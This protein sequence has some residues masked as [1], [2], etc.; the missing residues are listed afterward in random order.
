MRHDAFL[1]YSHTDAHLARE[2]E[3]G[4]ESL[5]KPL[6]K[7][8]ALD[9]FRDETALASSPALWPSI[10]EHLEAS[11][12][13]VLLAS[14]QSAASPWCAKELGWWL[15][16][17]SV[18][19]LL[20]VMTDGDIIWDKGAGEFDFARSTALSRVIEG[21]FRDEPLYT[22]LRWARSER[23]LGLRHP[24]FRDA[25]LNIAAPLRGIPKD[26]LD[27]VDVRQ[28]RRNR[29][30]VRTL[31][32]SIAAALVVAIWQ[33]RTATRER[34]EAQAQARKALS[35]KLVADSRLAGRPLDQ[36]LLLAAEAYQIAATVDAH[37]NLILL[38]HE[39][40]RYEQSLHAHESPVTAAAFVGRQLVTGDEQGRLVLWAR[41]FDSPRRSL[42]EVA[43]ITTVAGQ[44]I[45]VLR[46]NEQTGRLAAVHRNGRLTMVQVGDRTLQGEVAGS[47]PDWTG[48]RVVLNADA[49]RA[50]VRRDDRT[51]TAWTV[52]ASSCSLDLS[53]TSPVEKEIALSSSGRYL[54]AALPD[55]GVRWWSMDGR[56]GGTAPAAAQDTY[57]SFEAVISGDDRRIAVTSLHRLTVWEIGPRG[58]TKPVLSQPLESQFRSMAFSA[59][60][61]KLA[62]GLAD[63]TIDLWRFDPDGATR[64]P[65]RGHEYG[66]HVVDV[67][68][69]DLGTMLASA[70][71][72]GFVRLW[73]FGFMRDDKVLAR[74]LPGHGY[75]RAIDLLTFHS[76][77][78]V[79]GSGR[80]AILWNAGVSAGMPFLSHLGRNQSVGS[81]FHDPAT[82]LTLSLPGI[83][84]REQDKNGC[85]LV[86]EAR[87]AAGRTLTPDEMKGMI[88][89]VKYSP[90]CPR[91]Q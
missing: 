77:S 75:R 35:G 4:L 87:A 56:S 79:S 91:D 89:D 14:S 53:I 78:V 60:G 32:A 3:R 84:L 52:G 83:Q 63:G 46:A 34:D 19:R 37:E 64:E 59:R 28:L 31:F 40:D 66:L 7:L 67:A 15:E 61:D 44:P 29:R 24:R 49:S 71:E 88:G 45:E 20:L 10:L 22:D 38:A 30:F 57:P 16:H 51:V 25:V 58:E 23:S 5:A 54:A 82:G 36:T 9:I 41:S 70:A 48:A 86:A 8:R 18:D 12:W 85:A 17:R 26:E 42:V 50:I 62:V 27:G 6:L 43:A 47:C 73:Y 2:L 74:Q 69:N 68:F 13:L 72:D 11:E 33:W 21:R 39:N 90:T 81:S 1:S 65:L 80:S 76:D 55:G